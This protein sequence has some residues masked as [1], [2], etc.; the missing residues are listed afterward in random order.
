MWSLG[1]RWSFTIIW[2]HELPKSPRACLPEGWRAEI[3]HWRECHSSGVVPGSSLACPLLGSFSWIPW[4]D[5]ITVFLILPLPGAQGIVASISRTLPQGSIHHSFS[6][7]RLL[8]TEFLFWWSLSTQPCSFADI[9]FFLN[10]NFS[11]SS[12]CWSQWHLYN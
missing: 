3:T 9:T 11:L 10:N 2:Q 4:G 5:R 12:T 8:V 1:F 6:N 7:C